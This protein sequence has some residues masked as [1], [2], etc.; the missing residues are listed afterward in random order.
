[1]SRKVILLSKW[2]M[3]FSFSLT[4]NIYVYSAR[5]SI[6]ACKRR[7]QAS[8]ISL[9]PFHSITQP[10]KE[11]T[12]RNCRMVS[13]RWRPLQNKLNFV[14]ISYSAARQFSWFSSGHLRIENWF[15]LFF[16]RLL[17][18]YVNHLEAMNLLLILQERLLTLVPTSSTAGRLCC[19]SLSRNLTCRSGRFEESY[20]R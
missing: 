5:W 18:G 19:L 1:M 13:S 11:F 2:L 8:F 20:C 9:N 7:C 12:V 10:S 4:F 15:V 16:T 17:L 6:Q 3:L 14:R